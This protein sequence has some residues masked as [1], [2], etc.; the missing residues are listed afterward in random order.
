MLRFTRQRMNRHSLGRASRSAFKKSSSRTLSG[1]PA[2]SAAK[3]ASLHRP[4]RS[5]PVKP[6]VASARA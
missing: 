5:A 1:D 4:W 6:S 3:A 2:L